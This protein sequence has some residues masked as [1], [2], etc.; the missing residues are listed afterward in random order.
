MSEYQFLLF[1]VYQPIPN[2]S[3]LTDFFERICTELQI[4]G[5]I[6]V[7]MEGSNGIISGT[8]LAIQKFKM[9]VIRQ[10]ENFPFHWY[11]SGLVET[12]PRE[13]QLF[14]SLSVK[15][16]KEV[17]SLDLKEDIMKDVIE[18]SS[19][20]FLSPQQFHSY[21]SQM[22]NQSGNPSD[23][24]L[25]DIRNQY[26]VRIGKFMGKTFEAINPETRKVIYIFNI[27]AHLIYMYVYT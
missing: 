10:L 22:E 11:Q 12:L 18:A 8:L 25:I 6:R 5:R 1:Y 3:Y 13:I 14:D 27:F 24:K 17:V 21:L 26:E 7:S 20:K 4:R 23:I 15:I 19:G 16:T 2:C 9:D